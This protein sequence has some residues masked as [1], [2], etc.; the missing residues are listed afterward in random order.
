LRVRCGERT[1]KQGNQNKDCVGSTNHVNRFVEWD[2][3][4]LPTQNQQKA[5][6]NFLKTSFF[7]I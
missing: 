2:D 1:S 3:C 5:P 7:K 4:L 6:I